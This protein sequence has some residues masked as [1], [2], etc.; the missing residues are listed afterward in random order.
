[1]V[2][3]ARSSPAGVGGNEGDFLLSDLTLDSS[4]ERSGLSERGRFVGEG[5]DGSGEGKPR[6]VAR[7]AFWDAQ[8]KVLGL[9]ESSTV[10]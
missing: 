3:R 7:G 8:D 6:R 5:L 10:L 2:G 4:S 1:M 9:Y